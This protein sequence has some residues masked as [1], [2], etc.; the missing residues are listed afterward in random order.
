MSIFDLFTFKK[1]TEQVFS[2]DNVK[3]IVNLAREAIIAQAKNSFP[4]EEKKAKVDAQVIYAIQQ[5][6]SSCSNKLVLWLVGLVVKNVPAI[7]QKIYDFL[8]EKVENL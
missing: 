7:T 1:Q 3:F 8:K 5:K 2:R 4:G 6:V